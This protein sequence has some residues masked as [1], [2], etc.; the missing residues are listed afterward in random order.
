MKED[1]A[2]KGCGKRTIQMGKEKQLVKTENIS[3]M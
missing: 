1:I 2:E 3:I